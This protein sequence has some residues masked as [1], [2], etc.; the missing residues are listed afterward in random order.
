MKIKFS[1]QAA[2]GSPIKQEIY[3]T[4]NRL[5]AAGDRR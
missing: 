5:P 1:I 2:D 3:N 4:I